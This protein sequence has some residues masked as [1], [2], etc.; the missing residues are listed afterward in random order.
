MR[1]GLHP[2]LFIFSSFRAANS[3]ELQEKTHHS[4]EF[5]H[6]SLRFSTCSRILLYSFLYLYSSSWKSRSGFRD[7]H[8]ASGKVAGSSGIYT[9]RP[10][11]LQG[12]PGFTQSVRKSCRVF[13]DL[14]R[15]SGKVA[16]SSEI[17]T[18]RQEKLQGLPGFTQSIRECCRIFRDLNTGSGNV[19]PE[20]SIFVFLLPEA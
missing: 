16:G 5:I 20:V 19:A 9:E 1:L 6:C 11:K 10:E 13:R 7:L 15:A 14:H 12:I 17:H 2:G 4:P 3:G 8:R 18:E